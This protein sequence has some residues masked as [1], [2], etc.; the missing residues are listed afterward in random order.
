MLF[1]IYVMAVIL[2]QSMS[3]DHAQRMAEWK[4]RKNLGPSGLCET[5]LPYCLSG[6]FASF[7]LR[8]K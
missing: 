3:E 8:D 7:Y 4:V 2:S 6:L 1:R 5:G